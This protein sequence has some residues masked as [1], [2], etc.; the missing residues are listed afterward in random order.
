MKNNDHKLSLMKHRL[1]EKYKQGIEEVKWKLD[2]EQLEYLTRA[3][4]QSEP[5]LFRITTRTIVGVSKSGS[6]LLKEID[7]AKKNS[8]RELYKSLNAHQ[9]ELLKKYHVHYIPYK[10]RLKTR[11]IQH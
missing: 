1:R 7:H 6:K 3:G 4:Y 10:Y 9:E 8:K 2:E 5:Y 11:P